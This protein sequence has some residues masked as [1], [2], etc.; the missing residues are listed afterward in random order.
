MKKNRTMRAAALLLALT[1]M[2]SCFVGGTFAKYTTSDS[3]TDT[4]RVAKWGVEVLASGNLFGTNYN[5]N[6]AG[7]DGDKIAATS[8]TT[9]VDGQGEKVVAP[10]TKNFDGFTVKIS[11]VPEVSY[12]TTATVKDGTKDIFLAEGNWAVLVK[13][14]GLN[15]ATVVENVYYV[16]DGAGTYVKATGAYNPG[17][18]YY[19]L[20]DAVTLDE[21]Y[22]PLQ[23]TV[24]VDGVAGAP[25]T[26]I[27][28]IADAVAA[29]F[30][31]KDGT[32]NTSPALTY[33]LTWEWPFE[34]ATSNVADTILGNL[35]TG[36]STE[37][38]IVVYGAPGSSTYSAPASAKYN[39][40]VDFGFTVTVEQTN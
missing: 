12:A 15:A 16:N 2:T 39:L 13:A 40:I 31:A 8:V 32:A 11:G 29:A 22:Y 34:S 18:A 25:T 28:A 38:T 17:L 14:T 21:D 19:E 20:H 9:S 24:T 3:A 26:N 10:G 36:N 6:S 1:L 35:F 7:V 30:D 27:K 33:Q 23:W 5:P 37:E 4:A